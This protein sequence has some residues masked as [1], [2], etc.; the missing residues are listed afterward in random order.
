MDLQVA[1]PPNTTLLGCGVN[2]TGSLSIVGEAALGSTFTVRVH[3]PL[4]T[5]AVGSQPM[6]F[7][8]TAPDS[9]Y[10]CGTPMPLAN[11]APGLDGE[12]LIG[13]GVGQIIPV[14]VTGP[15]W[16]GS[17]SLIPLSIAQQPQLVGQTFFVQGLMVDRSVGAPVRIGL[18][19]AL[20]LRVGF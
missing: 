12:L 11:M 19:D 1:P 3:N 8:S 10:P 16:T 5:Q 17:P 4:G 18:T 7:F 14:V 13:A 15:A 6:L 9:N 2:P 20:E